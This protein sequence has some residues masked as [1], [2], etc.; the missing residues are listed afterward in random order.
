MH[1]RVRLGWQEKMYAECANQTRRRCSVSGTPGAG[2]G[3]AHDLLDVGLNRGVPV[4]VARWHR[5]RHSRRRAPAPLAR[6]RGCL[7][8]PYAAVVG[9]ASAVAYE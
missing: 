1:A 4:C 5:F 2:A 7:V 6:R 8:A 3:I 9:E